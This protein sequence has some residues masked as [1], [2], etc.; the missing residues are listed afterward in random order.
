M[1]VAADR[2]LRRAAFC[3]N[4]C[5]LLDVS[6]ARRVCEFGS[7]FISRCWNAISYAVSTLQTSFFTPQCHDD[8]LKLDAA[9]ELSMA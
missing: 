7:I 5:M 1:W 6:V 3:V 9:L 4:C 8:A 2:F